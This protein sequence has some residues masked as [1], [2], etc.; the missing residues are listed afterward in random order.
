VVFRKWNLSLGIRQIVKEDGYDNEHRKPPGCDPQHSPGR[1]VNKILVEVLPPPTI[2]G[3]IAFRLPTREDF[4]NRAREIADSLVQVAGVF[5]ERLD[6]GL[7]SK[8]D[9]QWALGE[10]EVTFSL[11]LESEAGVVIARATAKAGFQAKLTWKR[12]RT[13]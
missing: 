9:S 10:V 6:N 3:D 13:T 7:D 1:A 5:R 12:T 4:A 2:D 8:Q 11:D